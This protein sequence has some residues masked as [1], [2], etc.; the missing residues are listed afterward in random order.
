MIRLGLPADVIDK[1][2]RLSKVPAGLR[3][4]Q[5]ILKH[6]T[7]AIPENPQFIG[8]SVCY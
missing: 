3:S 7:A 4:R 6:Q 2:V 1:N 8:T 5:L